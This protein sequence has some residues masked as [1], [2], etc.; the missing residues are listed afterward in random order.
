MHRLSATITIS[1]ICLSPTSAQEPPP[2]AST[3]KL[4]A[5]EEKAK[6]HLPPG[7]EL[8][9]VASEPDIHKPLNMNFDERGRLWVTDTVEYPYPAAPGKGHDRIRI[10]D[11]FGPDGKARKITTFADGLNIPI[12]IV[13]YRDGCIAYD[14]PNIVRFH[15]TTGAGKADKREVL[16]G[17]IGTRDTHGMVNS[18]TFG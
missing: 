10:L 2:V 11:D 6:L 12:G 18:F 14:L 8:Q 13:P 9:L 4:S 15:D 17:P 3:N 7:F 1:L 5:A 16:Y